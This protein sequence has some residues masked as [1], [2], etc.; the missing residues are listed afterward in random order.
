[1]SYSVCVDQKKVGGTSRQKLLLSILKSAVY[2]MEWQ[3]REWECYEW[4]RGNGD[5]DSE[6]DW[7]R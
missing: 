6:T 1:M 7:L 2:P 5:S 4:V 3:W